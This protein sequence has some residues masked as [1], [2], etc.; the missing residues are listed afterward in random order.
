[1]TVAALIEALPS[2]EFATSE[3]LVKTRIE[4]LSKQEY[5]LEQDGYLWYI[6]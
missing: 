4:Y 1:M 3:E 2:F 6:P 5:L